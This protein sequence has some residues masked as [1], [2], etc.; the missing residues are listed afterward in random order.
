VKKN[1]KEHMVEV[2]PLL[3][4][5][6]PQVHLPLLLL[7]LP[8]GME[9]GLQPLL[10]QPLSLESYEFCHNQTGALSPAQSYA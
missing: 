10:D 2:K 6:H 7:L 5:H 8:M 3:Q 1:V 4:L 9:G